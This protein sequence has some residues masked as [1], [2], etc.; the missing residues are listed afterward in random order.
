MAREED[1]TWKGL[2]RTDTESF[3][4]AGNGEG[5]LLVKPRLHGGGKYQYPWEIEKTK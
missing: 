2:V 1:P 4:Q 3:T 5:F